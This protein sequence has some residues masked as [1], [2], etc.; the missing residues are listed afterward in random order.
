MKIIEFIKKEFK[1][2]Y[3]AILFA[4]LV[5]LIYVSPYLFFSWS[6]GS[7]YQGI[8]MIATANEDAY[9]GIMQE[10]IDGHPAVGS[11]PFFEYKDNWPL[12]PPVVAYFYALPALL[13]NISIVKILILSKFILPFVLFIL[14][15]FLINKLTENSWLLSNKMNAIAGAMLVT[16]GYDLVDFRSLLIFLKGQIT[17]GGKFLIWARPVNPI[18]GAIFLFSFLICLWLLIEK[19]KYRK[20]L[21]FFSSLFLAL[22]VSSYFFSWGMALSVLSVVTLIY[23]FKKE[24]QVVKNSFWILAWAIIMTLPYWYISFK[25]SQSPWYHDSVLR[26]GLF[27]THYPLLNLLVLAT[28]AVYLIMVFGS[29]FKIEKSAADRRGPIA[30]NFLKLKNWHWFCLSL[31][32][33]SVWAY[34]Q[35]II[36]GLTIWPFHFV[37]YTIPLS[38]VVICVLFYNIVKKWRPF[39]WALVISV[40][41]SLSFIFGVIVQ[42][43]T[44]KM[45]FDNYARLQSYKPVFNWLN[46][47][48]KDSVILVSDQNQGATPLPFNFGTLILA[49]THCNVYIDTDT[50]SIMPTDRL[51]HNYLVLLRLKGVTAQTIEPYLKNNQSEA[52]SYLY[53]NW[54]GVYKVKQF[55][56]FTDAILPERL[57]ELPEDFRQFMKQDFSEELKKYRLDYILSVGTLPDGL[58]RDLPNL[59][60]I[61]QHKDIQIYKF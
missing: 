46:Q 30:L 6:L 52:E 41:I 28:L 49:L 14:V 23:L 25:A 18:F 38:M 7:K 42:V 4:V 13:L 3:L 9:L 61:F 44:Y 31:L 50:F 22:M 19:S 58:Q 47:Q 36:T 17:L 2:H 5:G 51:L 34:S 56:D 10:I 59:K 27:Y 53:S 12:T 8:Q 15:Y 24:F 16:L 26:S 35:Q 60:R 29:I 1:Q 43:E 33:G 37:Q 11:F 39:L 40:M 54:K 57:E 20:S 55:P 32:L 21:I 45:N 48:E